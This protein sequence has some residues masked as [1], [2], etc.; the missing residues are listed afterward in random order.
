MESLWTQ[1]SQLAADNQ[2]LHGGMI[3]GLLGL[4]LTWLRHVPVWLFNVLKRRF[5]V[6]LEIR[7]EQVF[8]WLE[9]WIEQERY[10]EHC[11]VLSASRDLETRSG[12]KADTT[13]A[14]GL[15]FAPGRGHHVFRH[16]LRFYWLERRMDEHPGKASEGDF[17]MREVLVL[18]TWGSDPEPMKNLVKMAAEFVWRK[19]V[20]KVPI[21]ISRYDSWVQMALFEGRDL[22]SVVLATGQR[23]RIVRDIEQF[24]SREERYRELGVPYR[25]GYLL[26]GPPG[27]GKSSLVKAL[28]T[29][30]EM[31]LYLVT[32][33]S[34]YI[35]DEQL[36]ASM[37]RCAPRSIILFEDVDSLFASRKSTNESRVT[38]SG[39]LNCLDGVA[40]QNGRLVFLTTNHREVLD[41]ALLR[42]GRVDMDEYVGLCTRDQIERL[43][44]RYYP[45]NKRLAEA[46]AR[47]VPEKTIAPCDV[48][49][50]F[51]RH[52]DPR[53]I[54]KRKLTP[55]TNGQAH[56]QHVDT[57]V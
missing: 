15:V 25:R 24:L 45:G 5:T 21:Y 26:H 22:E 2:F 40:A 23:E 17:F 19:K 47:S 41:P 3:L 36:A 55:Q 9:E 7:D 14:P 35:T 54:D 8:R 53:Q 32:L 44:N 1:F 6:S 37:L 10:G 39:L 12:N 30:F 18:R 28:S 27:C 57:E 13:E 29:K 43:F 31:P 51:L 20:G 48:Q 4:V 49:N 38:F 11:R 52:D 42:G 56:A 50:L 16:G 34:P 33:S 46:F